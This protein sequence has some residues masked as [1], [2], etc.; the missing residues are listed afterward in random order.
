MVHTETPCCVK[1]IFYF[2][3]AFDQN[4]PR[5]LALEENNV[6]A[7]TTSQ[8]SAPPQ[9]PAEDQTTLPAPWAWGGR[10]KGRSGLP[11]FALAP[12]NSAPY[13]VSHCF[14]TLP[15]LPR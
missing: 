2:G 5:A 6:P 13:L 11:S 12:G 8:F 9:S 14:T 10:D 4:S 3:A 1:W 15:K 7:C